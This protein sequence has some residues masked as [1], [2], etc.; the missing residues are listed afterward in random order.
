[1]ALCVSDR[2]SHRQ[3]RSRVSKRKD[4]DLDEN[5]SVPGVDLVMDIFMIPLECD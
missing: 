2:V 3:G 4:M 1:M 5:F